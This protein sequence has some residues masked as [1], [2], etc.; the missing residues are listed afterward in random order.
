[1]HLGE[2]RPERDHGLEAKLSYTTTYRGRHGRDARTDG[3]FQFR[4][5]VKPGP[6]ILQA[7]YWGEERNRL[8][9]ILVDG[10]KIATQKLDADRPG[11]FFDV[12]YAIPEALTRGKST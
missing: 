2:M 7:T 5:K 4:M 10:Q 8:F 6:L 11:E 9:D 1:M 3:H 12:T